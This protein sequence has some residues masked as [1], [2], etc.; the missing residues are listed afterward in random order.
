[1]PTRIVLSMVIVAFVA[2]CSGFNAASDR[3]A[4]VITPYKMDIV[5]G[6]FVSA[7]QLALL[8]PG[9]PRAQVRELLGTPLVSSV[10]HGQRWDY[11]F[12]FRRQGVATQ[13]RRLTVFFTNDVVERIQTDTLPSEAEFVASLDSGRRSAPVPVLEL[14]ATALQ[15]LP[16][17]ARAAA[18]APSVIDLSPSYPP[19]ESSVR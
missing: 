10:F 12:T 5:Q 14:D 7:E 9:L 15:Q 18:S 11:I 19:L 8:K 6:N 17:P 4:S 3:I 2:G 1:M 16:R 13:A